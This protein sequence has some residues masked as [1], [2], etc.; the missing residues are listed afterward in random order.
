[1]AAGLATLHELDEQQLVEPF[2]AARR[3]A[4]AT[5]DAARRRVRRRQD[6][7]GLGLMW[8]IEFGEPQKGSRSWRLIERMQRGSSRS[9]SSLRSSPKHRILSQVA[10]HNL[11]VIKILPPLVVSDEDVDYFVEALRE[12]IKKAQRMP[13]ARDPLR[14]DR[15]RES[16]RT[17]RARRGRER[18]AMQPRAHASATRDSTSSESTSPLD[19]DDD[20]AEHRLDV[21]AELVALLGD[22]RERL[23][24]VAERPGEI[25]DL[26][27]RRVA[28][29]E[30]AEVHAHDKRRARRGRCTL[31][32]SA[33]SLIA[34]AVPIETST[35]QPR[36]RLRPR[37]PST[38]APCGCVQIRGRGDTPHRRCPGSTSAAAHRR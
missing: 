38:R 36:V 16:A 4:H 2:G 17:R 7:R 19:L 3:P 31:N 10:G 37:P 9:S 26:G 35:L 23:D 18:E 22:D 20:L 8:A 30:D 27:L 14:V 34:L 13:T 11:A 21:T 5:D 1:M 33:G 15:S 12:T 32:A 25:V 29:G 28:S 24:H 6:V